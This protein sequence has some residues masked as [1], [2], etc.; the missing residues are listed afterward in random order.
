MTY[1]SPITA[2]SNVVDNLIQPNDRL[3]FNIVKY[4]KVII[5][6]MLTFISYEYYYQTIS[7]SAELYIV[8]LLLVK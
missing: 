1:V 5:E 8:F 2:F 4:T 6:W 3:D 7:Y